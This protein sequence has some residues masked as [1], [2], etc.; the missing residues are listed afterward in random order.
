MFER[1]PNIDVVF[2]NGL[3]NLEVLPPT[4]V[5]DNIPP[6]PVRGTRNRVF[7]GIAAGITALLS[8]TLLATW[9]TRSNSGP[10]NLS[11]V[12]IADSDQ[13]LEAGQLTTASPVV[14]RVAQTEKEKESTVVAISPEYETVITGSGETTIPSLISRTSDKQL[15][16]EDALSENVA[17]NNITIVAQG[18]TGNGDNTSDLLPSG[19]SAAG[20]QRFM[21]GASMA[22][23]VGFSAS[24][25]DAHISD[26]MSGEKI[27]PA[28]TTGLTFGY[29]ISKRIT[30]QSG[31]GLS[32]MGQVINGIDVFAGLSD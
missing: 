21:V 20:E 25:N 14:G 18:L 6:M 24:G 30:I 17:D 8:L 27:R 29:K 28:Y 11:E 32:S 23:S 2:R 26:L 9:V 3:K 7:I 10:G 12:T 22:P 16:G 31:I 5:W 4:D 15:G 1:E 19:K 13:Y